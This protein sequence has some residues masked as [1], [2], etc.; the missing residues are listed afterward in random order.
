MGGVL[1][2]VWRAWNTPRPAAFTIVVIG[3][4]LT[5]CGHEMGPSLSVDVESERLVSTSS[6]PNAAS[7]CCCRV[8]G[9]VRNT[10]SISVHVNLNFEA[11]DPG[12]ASLGTA[13]DWVPNLAPGASAPFDAAGILA[14]CSQVGTL[15]GRHRITGVY[16]GSGP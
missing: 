3:A 8:R 1:V 4:A 13:I 12:D 9:N 2:A 6:L 11:R 10:S 16:A 5:S 14:P 15:T 7:L